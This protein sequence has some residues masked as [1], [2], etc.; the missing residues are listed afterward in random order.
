MNEDLVNSLSHDPDGMATYE[1]LVNHVDDCSDCIDF[2]VGSI[3]GSDH[4]GQFTASSAIYLNAV[5]REKFDHHIGQLVEATIEKDRERRYLPSLIEQIWGKD[6]QQRV[7]ELNET[8]NN[9]RRIYKRL[10]P[11]GI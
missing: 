11:T 10:F 7:D 1:Y 6:Y 8:D 9:F 3:C 2:L 5:D 4:C